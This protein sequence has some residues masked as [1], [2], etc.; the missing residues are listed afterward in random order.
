MEISVWL[1]GEQYQH[2]VSAGA[3]AAAHTLGGH[4]NVAR[5]DFW[6]SNRVREYC[7]WNEAHARVLQGQQLPCCELGRSTWKGGA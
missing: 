2:F 4:T 5:D 3:H 1:V 7:N 6:A